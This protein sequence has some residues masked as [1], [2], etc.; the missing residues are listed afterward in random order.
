MMKANECE[1]ELKL[2]FKDAQGPK[3]TQCL[4]FYDLFP[5]NGVVLLLCCHRLKI[6][7]I[8][9]IMRLQKLAPSL[10]A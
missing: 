1:L 6:T 5:R 2:V 9:K 10:D 7:L 3:T 8:R 4:K